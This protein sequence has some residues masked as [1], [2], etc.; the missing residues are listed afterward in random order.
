[1]KK[2]FFKIGI[3]NISGTSP[4]SLHSSLVERI[5]TLLTI[6]ISEASIQI[7]NGS[8]SATSGTAEVD[9]SAC[10]TDS[11]SGHAGQ[12]PGSLTP[13]ETG[14]IQRC[15]LVPARVLGPHAAV[16]LP[17]AHRKPVVSDGP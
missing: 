6:S 10:G 2:L 15:A 4:S 11:R 13:R 3:K 8:A 17:N 7:S 1:M 5:L 9:A 14:F 12:L 16:S